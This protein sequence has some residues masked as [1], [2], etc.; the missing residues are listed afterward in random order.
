MKGFW[1]T[2]IVSAIAAVSL[3]ALAFLVF[4]LSILSAEEYLLMLVLMPVFPLVALRFPG[5]LLA[6]YLYI[7]FYKAGIQPLLP[8]DLTLV[9]AVGCVGI[10][11]LLFVRNPYGAKID[12]VMIWSGFLV[13]VAS[14]V[15]VASDQDLANE[16]LLNFALLTWLPLTLAVHVGANRKWS[17]QFLLS[18]LVLSL[19]FTL[20]GLVTIIVGTTGVRLESMSNTI[21][22]SRAAL[23][24]VVVLLAGFGKDSRSPARWLWAAVPLSGFVAF[25]TGSRGPILA[26]MI[27]LVAVVIRLRIREL[28][29]YAGWGLLAAILVMLL[30]G[31]GVS[32][33]WVPE[34]GTDRIVSIVD[35]LVGDA[36]LDGSASTR[37]ELFTHAREMFWERPLLGFGT[38]GFEQNVS[39]SENLSGH[40]YPHN[41]LLQFASDFGL[42]GLLLFSFLFVVATRRV[43]GAHRDETYAGIFALTIFS[44]V[45]AML[46]N[47]LYDNRWMWGMLLIQLT[48]TL[49][50]TRLRANVF[51]TESIGDRPMSTKPSVA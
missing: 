10:S 26:L 19:I 3:V 37:L 47:D 13:L 7:P 35:A 48:Y 20:I 5:L 14:G 42:V 23:L 50:C 1:K 25:A 18:T 27:A 29:R 36:E 9:L 11:C 34:V 21:G 16:T 38:A 49:A 22:T 51:L 32:K 8:V 12:A 30:V 45:S 40:S 6:A 44:V 43:R 17:N 2:H 28:P 24:L 4:A 41:L 39:E 31:S 33:N 15:L 46:S